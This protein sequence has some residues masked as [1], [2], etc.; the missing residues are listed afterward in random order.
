ME[1]EM[2]IQS[3][4]GLYTWQCTVLRA[5]CRNALEKCEQVSCL[6]YQV[7]EVFDKLNSLVDAMGAIN[8]FP[9]QSFVSANIE[10]RVSYLF[11]Y[12]PIPTYLP[13]FFLPPPNYGGRGEGRR[14]VQI[15][16]LMLAYVSKFSTNK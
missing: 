3:G 14:E 9:V 7:D 6:K 8:F 4:L 10:Y 16:V 5:Y 11:I 12:L 15:I 2:I 1:I 13:T